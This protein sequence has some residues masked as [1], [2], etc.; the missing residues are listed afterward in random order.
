VV[1]E[2][3]VVQAASI[4]GKSIAELLLA[5]EEATNKKLLESSLRHEKRVGEVEGRLNELQTYIERLKQSSRK[6]EALLG[7]RDSQMKQLLAKISS[8]EKELGITTEELRRKEGLIVQLKHS[9][10]TVSKESEIKSFI[11]SQIENSTRLSSKSPLRKRTESVRR[12]GDDRLPS[13]YS[14]ISEASGRVSPS[15]NSKASFGVRR[16][17]FDDSYSEAAYSKSPTIYKKL[18]PDDYLREPVPR[19]MD[20][21]EDLLGYGNRKVTR[22]PRRQVTELR[23]THEPY[24]QLGPLIEQTERDSLTELEQQVSTGGEPLG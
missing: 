18:Q 17:D 15:F 16:V 19:S 3:S 2:G 8:L 9:M 11:V 21:K 10:L 12:G 20:F 14:P 13:L 5:K 6:T 22:Q 24:E 1:Y 4:G 23:V 7:Q